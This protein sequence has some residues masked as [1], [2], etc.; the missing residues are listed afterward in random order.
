MSRDTAQTSVPPASPPSM[1]EPAI[2]LERRL[3][4]EKVLDLF[5]MEPRVREPPSH[6][7]KVLNIFSLAMSS[8]NK[9]TQLDFYTRD[10]DTV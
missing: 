1:Y 7:F 6:S 5:T 10:S 4:T 8:S 9:P 3:S 2:S